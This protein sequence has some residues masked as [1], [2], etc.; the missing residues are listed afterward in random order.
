MN[1]KKGKRTVWRTWF[2]STLLVLLLLTA[3][4][5]W[6][7][8]GRRETV[9]APQMF[10]PPAATA[11]QDRR[12]R[13]EQAYEQDVAALQALLETGAADEAT[14]ELAAQNLAELIRQ[15]QHE[16][17]LEAALQEAGFA[18]AVVIV[19]NNAVT[20][21]IPQDRL[22]EDASA[23]ILALC[24]AHTEVGAENVRVM[25]LPKQNK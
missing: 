18:A 23:Q 16:I 22:N 2:R 21:M 17:G 7:L 8:E 6:W 3:A 19:Q 24:V 1:E 20:V 4:G 5:L 9:E 12:T 14:Q 15:H 10:A 11:Q 13:Q 25:A